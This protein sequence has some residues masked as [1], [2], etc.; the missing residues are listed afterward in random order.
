MFSNTSFRKYYKLFFFSFLII[1]IEL[2][3]H[4][5]GLSYAVIFD[6]IRLHPIFAPLIFI[7]LLMLAMIGIVPT[8]PFNLGAGILFGGIYG[9]ILSTIGAALGSIASFLI[10]RNMSN[11]VHYFLD[12]KLMHWIDNELNTN[13]WRIVAMVRLCPGIPTGPINYI[14][15]LTKIN[16]RTYSW[17][18][19]IF[20]L[21]P[22]LV[23][24]IMGQHMGSY[25]IDNNTTNMI[26]LL[27]ALLTGISVLLFVFP[28]LFKRLFKMK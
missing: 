19:F 21:P 20:L 26:Y 24:S 22:N 10:A 25:I 3:F 12:N 11:Y 15:G 7:V 5:Y 13:G 17:V 9:G 16:L 1:L 14:F 27:M 28:N 4:Y 6:F 23:I 8:L 18:T 2:F